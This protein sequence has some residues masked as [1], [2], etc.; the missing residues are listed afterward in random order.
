MSANLDLVRAIYET[1]DRGDFSSTE[2]AHPGIEWV[3][4]DGPEPGTRTG[5]AG[6]AQGFADPRGADRG[7]TCTVGDRAGR[8]QE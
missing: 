1:R 2:W 7:A 3:R 6:M 5:L 4:P 8:W